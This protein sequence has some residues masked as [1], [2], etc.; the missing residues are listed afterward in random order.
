MARDR[1]GTYFFMRNARHFCP[2]ATKHEFFQPIVVIA[3]QRQPSCSV[4]TDEQRGQTKSIVSFLH[5][6]NSS[7]VKHICANN[8]AQTLN[9]SM[10][11]ESGKTRMLLCVGRSSF[12]SVSFILYR[13]AQTKLYRNHCIPVTMPVTSLTKQV[14]S[15]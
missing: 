3:G 8:I 14:L 4:R 11:I 7:A 5:G 1:K 15:K 13:H 12:L 2:I 6:D 9:T 10:T